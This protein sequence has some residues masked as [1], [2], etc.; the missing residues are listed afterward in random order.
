MPSHLFE[1]HSIV[2][3]SMEYPR[4]LFSLELNFRVIRSLCLNQCATDV[5]IY[6]LTLA[7][8][9]IILYHVYLFNINSR[10]MDGQYRSWIEYL[11]EPY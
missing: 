8:P 9:F 11:N 6:W 3:I 4:N 7:L 5:N 10:K 2:M 1:Y